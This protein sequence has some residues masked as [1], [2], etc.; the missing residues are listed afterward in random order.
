MRE[1]EGM[2]ITR[3]TA[4]GLLAAPMV[5]GHGARGEDWPSRPV[6]FVVP[7][8]P[9][10]P[11]DI[12]GRVAAQRAAMLLPQPVVVE[13]RAGAGG[14][15]GAEAVAR[16]APDGATFLVNAS[17]HVIVPHMIRVPY[18]A[19]ADFAPVTQI[20]SVPLI[21]TVTPSLPVRSVAELL[22]YARANPGKLAY[23]S[24]SNGGAPHLAGEMFKL[25]AG[26]DLQHVPY[27][28]SGQ[29]LPD[30]VA[31]NVQL[32]F[33]SAASSADLV[34]EGR[35]R[36][37]AVTTEARIPAFPDL[38]TVAEAGVPGYAIATWYGIWAPAR[39]PEA[40]I[41]RLQ[42]AVAEGLATPEA[43]ERLA[44]L[45]AIPVADT[46]ERFGAFLRTEWTRY[47]EL[48]RDAGIKAD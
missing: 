15:I 36:P 13:N 4:L 38:P 6:R 8:P 43:A 29:A 3:R 2:R 39:T 19:M 25:L 20:A 7:Y 44:A 45:G 48:V 30:L 12:L 11:T 34:R 10:G 24:S 33:D 31:G 14:S 42:G 41:G 40:I 37:L 21:L 27:R 26:V 47:A 17:A 23:A 32:M 16:A 22:A 18:D 35:L 46:P 1:G 5:L 28:G 9:G